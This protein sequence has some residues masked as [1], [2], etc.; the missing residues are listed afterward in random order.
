MKKLIVIPILL[1]CLYATAQVRFGLRLGLSTSQLE[2]EDFNILQNGTER[3]TL[4]LKDAQYGI[5]GGVVI[6]AEMG[7]FIL[8]PEVLFNSNSANF[9]LDDFQNP[10][11]VARKEK[12]QYLDIPVM[13]GYRLGFLRLNAGPV[14]HIF[15]NSTSNI[16]DVD[17]FEEDFKKLTLGW[18]GGLGLDIGPI[19]VDV[20]YEGNFN[21]FGDHINFGDQE[22][23][24][25][26]SPA[27]FIAAVTYMFGDRN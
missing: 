6:Q 16:T 23:S 19:A 22:Y 14:G 15:L 7:N 20:R 3:F 4:A 27:R 13:L 11:E 21:K 24:F 2:A 5:H 25:S 9:T 10:G 17:G 1:F 12:Y 26:Q 8:Q 18:Q